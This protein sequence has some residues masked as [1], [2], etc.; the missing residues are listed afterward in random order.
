MENAIQKASPEASRQVYNWQFIN[1]LRVW[2]QVLCAHARTPTSPLRQ[3]VYPLVQVTL[4]TARLL[5]SSRYAALRFQCARILN[6]LS[7]ELRVAG[8][9][10]LL[11]F[12]EGREVHRLEGVPGNEDALAA[13]VREHLGV[14]V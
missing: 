13:I 10:T 12:A 1:C 2:A 9:P 14:E 4:G 7:S 5:P 6:Q 11:F 8:L 3:L